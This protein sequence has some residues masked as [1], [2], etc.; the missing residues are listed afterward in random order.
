MHYI[1]TYMTYLHT[2]IYTY[3]HAY[4]HIYIHAYIHTLYTCIYV[5]I[6]I[7]IYIYI[8]LSLCFFSIC[9]WGAAGAIRS[10]FISIP[11]NAPSLSAV[12]PEWRGFLRAVLCS[13]SLSLLSRQGLVPLTTVTQ[14]W[15]WGYPHRLVH[16]ATSAAIKTSR[17]GATRTKV[18]PSAT[19]ATM[20]ESGICGVEFVNAEEPGAIELD[21]ADRTLMLP[22]PHGAP[23][24]FSNV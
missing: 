12:F 20:P 15:L 14:P 8:Y 3:I 9:F 17:P 4:I 6:Y 19:V 1:H 18:H 13:A 5:K 11:E 2:Y 7:Y 16:P 24:V 22:A 10:L 23:R 21:N